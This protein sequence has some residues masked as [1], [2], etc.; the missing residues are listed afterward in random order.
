MSSRS[1]S[2]VRRRGG[3]GCGP[4]TSG[5]LALELHPDEKTPV[6]VAFPLLIMTMMIF[7]K[8]GQRPGKELT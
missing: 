7:N 8:T 1:I 6:A 4:T 2:G 3:H 5:P